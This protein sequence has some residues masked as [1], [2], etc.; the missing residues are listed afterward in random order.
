MSI[1]QCS[2]MMFLSIRNRTDLCVAAWDSASNLNAPCKGFHSNRKVESVLHAAGALEIFRWCAIHLRLALTVG[3]VAQW[4]GRRSLAGWLFLTFAWSMVDMWQLSFP[5]LW[6][7]KWVV[8]HVK[9]TWIA[10]VKT[11]KRQTWAAYGWLVV[12][13]SLWAQA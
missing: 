11:I 6:I 1:T 7:G 4:L 13:Q 10:G 12:G 2:K 5:S 9:I 3:G 8:I